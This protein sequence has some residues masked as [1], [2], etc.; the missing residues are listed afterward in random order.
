MALDVLFVLLPL[1]LLPLWLLHL[2][3]LP[4]LML[5]LPL[6]GQGLLLDPGK[7]TC[8]SHSKQAP[9]LL[10]AQRMTPP[11]MS[12]IRDIQGG[13]PSKSIFGLCR[14][15]KPR[16]FVTAVRSLGR[17]G[18]GSEAGG[19]EQDLLDHRTRR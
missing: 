5:L 2:P 1:P 4:L 18:R 10:I 17:E 15:P 14:H 12:A 3:R 11:F 13:M 8:G 19:E 7:R 9:C 6:P 16:A